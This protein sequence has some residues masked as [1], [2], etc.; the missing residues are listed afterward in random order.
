MGSGL[1]RPI[2]RSTNHSNL[3]WNNPPRKVTVKVIILDCEMSRRNWSGRPKSGCRAA[4]FFHSVQAPPRFWLPTAGL[5]TGRSWAPNEALLMMEPIVR[6]T[7]SVSRTW[8]EGLG[9][10]PSV[11]R[12]MRSIHLSLPPESILKSTSE[13]LQL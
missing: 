1:W 10:P 11:S 12:W 2:W 6:K 3:R 5:S 7:R 13:I 9:S 4:I 8:M